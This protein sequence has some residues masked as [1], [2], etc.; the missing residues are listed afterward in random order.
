MKSIQKLLNQLVIIKKNNI[1]KEYQV[2]INIC[3]SLWLD[4]KI[5]E[6]NK[7]NNTI[8]P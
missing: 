8:S 5:L 1:F 4:E 2:A 7:N 6:Y 3:K